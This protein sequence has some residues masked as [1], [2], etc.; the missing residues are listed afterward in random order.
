M[1]S[2]INSSDDIE[3]NSSEIKNNPLDDL[4]IGN[5][6]SNTSNFF[7]TIDNNE[8]KKDKKIE[9]EKEKAKRGRKARDE[10]T[11]RRQYQTK[12][13]KKEEEELISGKKEEEV[14]DISDSEEEE[15]ISDPSNVKF[16]SSIAKKSDGNNNENVKHNTM[17]KYECIITSIFYTRYLR[18]V[19]DCDI[20]NTEDELRNASQN[21]DILIEQNVEKVKPI[22]DLLKLHLGGADIYENYDIFNY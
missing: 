3:H 8:K 6:K 10:N 1:A 19:S 7:D 14:K 9:Q 4:M 16:L 21:F 18:T 11:P 20:E 15:D 13:R 2:Y 22:N 12:K 5:E 17:S